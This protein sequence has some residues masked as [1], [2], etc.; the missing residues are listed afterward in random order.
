PAHRRSAAAQRA[1]RAAELAPTRAS[2]DGAGR[3]AAPAGRA[4]PDTVTT[5]RMRVVVT[6]PVWTLNGVNTFSASLVRA[7]RDRGVDASLLLTGVDWRDPKPLPLPADLPITSLALPAV[8]T[9]PA[10]W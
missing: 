2:L 3:R 4:T 8:A 5:P 9:W 7:L 10:R 1:D 6:S